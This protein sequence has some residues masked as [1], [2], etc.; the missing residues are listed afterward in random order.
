MFFTDNSLLLSHDEILDTE[1]I[2]VILYMETLIFACP[3]LVSSYLAK[4]KLVKVDKQIYETLMENSIKRI[5]F[6]FYLFYRL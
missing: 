6:I 3:I 5:V 2:V 4:T 1:I